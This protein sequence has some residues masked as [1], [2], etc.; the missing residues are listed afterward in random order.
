MVVWLPPKILSQFL[1]F[2]SSSVTCRVGH[3][4]L[5]VSIEPETS[6]SVYPLTVPTF[7][8]PLLWVEALRP[9]LAFIN[10]VPK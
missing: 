6:L 4:A 10:L 2:A 7:L 8:C 9:A 1:I 5:A 3:H